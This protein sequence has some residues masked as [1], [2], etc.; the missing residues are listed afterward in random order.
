MNFD[1]FTYSLLDFN[2]LNSQD[3]KLVICPEDSYLEDS[4]ILQDFK[5]TTFGN[6]LKTEANKEFD[7]ALMKCEIEK[8]C[9]WGFQ[10]LASGGIN[11]IW[12]KCYT[13]I[14]K[15]INI[16]NPN[17]PLWILEKEKLFRRI[18]S[19]KIFSKNN[20]LN[21]R[22]I[23]QI[24][25][26]L[27]ELIVFICLSNKRKLDTLSFKF[28]INEFDLKTFYTR[29]KYKDNIAIKQILGPSD[30]KEIVLACNELYYSIKNKNIQ[31][32]LYWLT[33]INTWEKINIKKYKSFTVQSRSI[34]GIDTQHQKDVT[35]LVWSVIQYAAN[36]QSFTDKKQE[37]L[38]ALWLLYIF[39][40]KP[41]QKGKR[42]P[43]IV[44]YLSMVI[45]PFNDFNI[46]VIQNTKLYIKVISNANLMFKK[47]KSQCN[48]SITT[49]LLDISRP[50]NK[51]GSNIN[52]L[53]QN[54][55]E[56]SSSSI[57]HNTKTTIKQNKSAKKT[58]SSLD[59]KTQGKLDLMFQLDGYL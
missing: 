29:L 19:N 8:A 27:T 17:A 23:Q 40:W 28:N 20:I 35:W 11:Q 18:V 16:Q 42:L 14:Y 39:N 58:K 34:E 22:N 48:S 4:R 45:S 32:I 43:I 36:T 49:S 57:P 1:T 50:T 7:L 52:I 12:D 13:I 5:K 56:D 54:N 33:W 55:Y 53:V 25:N 3:F 46:P 6:H 21:T 26:I 31:D 47:M 59:N 30:S 24:R 2:K 10:I 15:Q 41:G 44:W 51:I 37:N 38:N 9:Y